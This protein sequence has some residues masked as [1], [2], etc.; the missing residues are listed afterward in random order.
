MKLNYETQA[1]RLEGVENARQL[2]GISCADG[3]KVR[4]NVLIRTGRLSDATDADIDRLADEFHV[5]RV[6][7]FRMESEHIAA[8]DREIPGAE[9]TWIEV[10]RRS[11]VRVEVPDEYRSDGT[12]MLI[13]YAL[14]LMPTLYENILRSPEGQAG[15]ARFFR[16]ILAQK[17][18]A[19][20]WHCSQGK[21]RAGIAA[22][23]L[24]LALGADEETAL[25]DFE[26]SS[27]FYAA[28]T[29]EKVRAAAKYGYTPSQQEA[30]RALTGV[31]REYMRSALDAV[32]REYGSTADYLRDQLGVTD[33]DIAVLRERYLE[34]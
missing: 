2:G 19:I 26:L 13:E 6:F 4:P 16:E 1:I 5:T 24:L 11:A 21:D 8:P 31:S 32:R 25:D 34:K 14:Q 28:Y 20:L 12:R 18:G 15:Y 30:V 23:L 9:N 22:V 27:V 3:R 33:E 7:D 17:D 10:L 29:R